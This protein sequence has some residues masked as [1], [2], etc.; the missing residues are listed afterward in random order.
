MVEADRGFVSRLEAWA[1]SANALLLFDEVITFRTE[2]GGAQQRFDVAPDLTSLGKMIGGGFPVGAVA[3]RAEVMGVFTSQNGRVRLPLSGTF[4]ANP[5]TMTAGRIAMEHFD[6]SAVGRL[7]SLGES[8][9]TMLREVITEFGANASVTGAGSLFRIHFTSPAPRNYR[10]AYL[11]K[12]RK[13]RLDR[14]LSALFDRGV[15]LTNTGAGM[16]STAMGEEE[17]E[18][19][20]HAVRYGLEIQ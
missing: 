11:D 12:E 13:A 5:V 15:M 1:R 8:I 9:R 4:N 6:S 14:F 19:L 2:Y 7:N 3:G 17:G 18:Q 10:E 16:L 20:R